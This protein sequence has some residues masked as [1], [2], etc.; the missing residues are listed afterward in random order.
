VAFHWSEANDAPG[1][2]VP[3]DLTVALRTHERAMRG[4]DSTSPH[5]IALEGKVGE[6]TRCCI[7]DARPSPCRS[8]QASWENGAADPHCDRARQRYGLP[9]LTA[10]DWVGR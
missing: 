4:T 3:V 8:V 10:D 2:T 7:Y 1:G 6:A 9:V 5:C